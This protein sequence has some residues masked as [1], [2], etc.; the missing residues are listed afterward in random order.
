VAI[1]ACGKIFIRLGVFVGVGVTC[2]LAA[3]PQAKIGTINVTKIYGQSNRNL[4]IVT[5]K[6]FINKSSNF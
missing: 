5:S 6:S 3:G 2:W 4:L 1:G